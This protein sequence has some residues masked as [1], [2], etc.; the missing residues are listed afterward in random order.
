VSALRPLGCLSILGLALVTPV[1]AQQA[2]ESDALPPSSWRLGLSVDGSWY[3]NLSFV[4]VDQRA[5]AWSTSGHAR[6]TNTRRF[7]TGTLALSGFGGMLYYPEADDFSQPTYGGSLNLGVASRHTQ[8]T[9]GQVYSRSNTR[10]LWELDAEGLPLRTSDVENA[11]TNLGLRHQLSQ[12]WQFNMGG[13]FTWRSYGDERLIGGEQ[14]SGSAS[15]GHTFGRASSIFL[16]YGLTASWFDTGVTRAHQGM[17]GV[18]KG[19]DKGVSLE[20]AGGASYLE[21]TETFYPAGHALLS[22]AGRRASFTLAYSRDFGH[23]FGYGRQMIGDLATA[24]LAWTATRKLS[25]NAG[26]NFGYRRDVNDETYTIQSHIASAGFGWSIV[27]GLSF[28]GSYA[29]QRNVT[30]RVATVEGQRATVS[31]SYGIDW[32]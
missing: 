14:L 12:H 17:L 29:W 5:S 10:T 13:G 9:L 23:A 11:T 16:A 25:L 19:V 18:R 20:L 22:V 2:I 1:R 24:R 32:R 15:L 6:L 27:K 21:S 3:Q 4:T 30:R 8:F 28:S 31:L 26:Y 7:R